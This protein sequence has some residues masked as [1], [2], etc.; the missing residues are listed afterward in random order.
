MIVES[1]I[2]LILENQLAMMDILNYIMISSLRDFSSN[3]GRNAI[4]SNSLMMDQYHKTKE[5]LEGV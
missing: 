5:K 3:F 1:D 4:H 2:K